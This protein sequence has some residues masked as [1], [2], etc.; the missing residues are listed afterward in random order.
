MR[1]GSIL[2]ALALATSLIAQQPS[3]TAPVSAH[4]K[5]RDEHRDKTAKN[6]AMPTGAAAMKGDATAARRHAS[7]ALPFAYRLIDWSA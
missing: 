5:G 4:D 7:A 6:D 1:H 3:S 2:L